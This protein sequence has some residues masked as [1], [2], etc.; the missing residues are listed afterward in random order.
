MENSMNESAMNEPASSEPTL[1]CPKCD[2]AMEQGFIIDNTHGGRLVPEWYAGEPKKS[3]WL[4]LKVPQNGI[5]IGV[6]RCT[7]CGY[8][9]S[10]ASEVFAAH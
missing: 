9:E 10:Y 3:L 8:L 6:F 4:G 1:R 5:P 7:N 2:A